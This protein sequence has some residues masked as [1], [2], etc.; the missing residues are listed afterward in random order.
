M[1]VQV[2][3][4][5]YVQHGSVALAETLATKLRAQ[6][7]NPY[8]IPV[9][10][11]SALGTWGYMEAFREMQ[12]QAPASAGFSDIVMVSSSIPIPQCN[13]PDTCC[14]CHI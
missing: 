3:K 11:S 9:G 7:L 10:G 12:Q 8:I 13:C 2:T 14:A 6:G 4:E 1:L 5:E